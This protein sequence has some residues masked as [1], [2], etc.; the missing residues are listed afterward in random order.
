[1][2]TG[3]H[4]VSH[5]HWDREC[6]LYFQEHRARLVEMLKKALKNLKENSSKSFMF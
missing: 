2:S 3:V 5:T 6:Y 4:V 1:M